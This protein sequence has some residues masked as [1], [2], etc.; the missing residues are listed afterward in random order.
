M[1]LL[2]EVSGGRHEGETSYYLTSGQQRFRAI[3]VS[4][5]RAAR[6]WIEAVGYDVSRFGFEIRVQDESEVWSTFG[7]DQLLR[8][9]EYL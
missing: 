7:V 5:E 3:A 4:A 2:T 9:E 8:P 1:T 6:K